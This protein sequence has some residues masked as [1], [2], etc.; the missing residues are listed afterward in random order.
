MEVAPVP[1]GVVKPLGVVITR[2]VPPTLKGWKAVEPFELSPANTIGLVTM[3]PTAALEL[4]TVTLTVRPVRIDCK[5][6]S[7]SVEGFNCAAISERDV[8]PE[9][10]V[11]EKLPEFHTMPEGV[12]VTVVVALL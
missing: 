9:V 4:V 3:V 7:V 11:V 5:L 8:S 10:V 12:R 6:F 2:L 1:L